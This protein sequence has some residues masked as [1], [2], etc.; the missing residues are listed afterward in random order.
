[1]AALFSLPTAAVTCAVP[2]LSAGAIAV[3]LV[4]DAQLTAVA[5]RAARAE[6]DSRDCFEARAGGYE[7]EV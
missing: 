6:A 3:Q 1:L 7:A 2:A 4:L 5:R